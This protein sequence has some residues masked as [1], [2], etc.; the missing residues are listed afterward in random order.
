MLRL[1][2][3]EA[4]IPTNTQ[5]SPRWKR[6]QK[7]RPRRRTTAARAHINAVAGSTAGRLRPRWAWKSTPPPPPWRRLRCFRRCCCPRCRC[8]RRASAARAAVATAIS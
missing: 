7:R 6:G 8:R 1:G 3:P 4:A 2:K 5:F